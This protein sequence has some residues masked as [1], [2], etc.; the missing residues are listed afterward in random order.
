MSNRHISALKYIC[1]LNI[2][3]FLRGGGGEV[4]CFF[5]LYL[6]ETKRKIVD[7]SKQ[8][9]AICLFE[10]FACPQILRDLI[11]VLSDINSLITNWSSIYTFSTVI[12]HFFQDY[13]IKTT[14][15]CL[16]LLKL[17]LILYETKIS[18]FAQRLCKTHTNSDGVV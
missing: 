7:H 12:H 6:K 18:L 15:R 8:F 11:L 17:L 14:L 9:V 16:F 10:T 2:I 13:E 5:V 1:H 4:Q 3:V